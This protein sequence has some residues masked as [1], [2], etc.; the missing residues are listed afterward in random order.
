[1]LLAIQSILIAGVIIV[2]FFFQEDVSVRT[3]QDKKLV[4]PQAP[5]YDDVPLEAKAAYLYDVLYDREI[6]KKNADA[7]LPLAS[8]TKLMTALVAVELFPKE[9]VVAIKPEF[10]LEEGDSG[11]IVGDEWNIQKLIDYSLV[12][13]SNDASRALASVIGTYTFHRPEYNMG[14]HD[15]ILQMNKRAKDI[16]LQHTYFVNETGLDTGETSGGYGSA[17]DVGKLMMYILSEYPEIVE[18]TRHKMYPV[19]SKEKEYVAQNT[20]AIVNTIPYVLASK[21]GF[22][23]LA[24]GNLVVAFDISVGHPVVAVVL[25]SSQN[26]RFADIQKLVDLSF[27]YGKT[28]AKE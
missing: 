6:Y 17:Q 4:T 10:L 2:A 5:V 12:V 3:Y 18:A 1:M 14:R 25:G 11:L 21:T 22:T 9:S 23:N 8:I 13:S 20:N 26:G 28:I 27:A 19:D 15:F 7:Q 24:Q 16:G